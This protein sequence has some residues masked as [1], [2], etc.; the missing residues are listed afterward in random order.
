[1][2]KVSNPLAVAL[3]R[4]SS[5]G[6]GS[7]IEIAPDRVDARAVLVKL[8][9]DSTTGSE[10]AQ[11]IQQST[12]LETLYREMVKALADLS[13]RNNDREL[14]DMLAKQGITVS[15]NPPAAA[16]PPAPEPKKGGK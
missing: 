16:A 5:G 13:V 10:R 12:Q 3:T 6:I 9:D 15:A 8:G 11:Y 1:M 7:H 14:R 2:P 4:R